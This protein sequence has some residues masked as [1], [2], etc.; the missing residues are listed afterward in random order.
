MEKKQTGWISKEDDLSHRII[1]AAIEVHKELGPGL[2]ESAYEACLAREMELR[3]IPFERQLPLPVV[4]KDLKLDC[5]YRM[6]LV[7]DDSVIIQ[8]KSVDALNEVHEAQCLSYLRFS[9]KRLCLLLNFNTL[10]MKEGIKRVLL[11]LDNRPPSRSTFSAL[12]FFATHCAFLASLC[13]TLKL[14]HS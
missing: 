11:H 3:G 9:N 2:L 1:G 5:G 13:V 12:L 14:F 7:A 10:L 4:H 6:D 8:V